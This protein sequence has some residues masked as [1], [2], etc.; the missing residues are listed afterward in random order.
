MRLKDKVALV[1][2]AANGIG[3]E[4][5]RL[6]V[7]EGAKVAIFDKSPRVKEV[8]STIS[9]TG[10]DVIGIEGDVVDAR[11]VQEAVHQTTGTFGG[12]DVLVNNAG[13]LLIRDIVDTD[14]QDWDATID[15]NLKGT[16]FFSKFAVQQMIGQGRGGSIVNIGSDLGVVGLAGYTAYCAAKGAVVNFTRALAMECGKHG[17][18]VN[19]VC[20]ASIE[21]PMMMSGLKVVADKVG[22]EKARELY[23]APLP[24]GRFGKSLD[25]ARAVLFVA[26]D[27]ASYV[28]GTILMCDGG[29]T[30]H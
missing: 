12:L 2:G 29:K 15:V 8:V 28:T 22:S 7:A 16:F 30:C 3:T 4:I 24:I 17:I 13:A 19:C 1:T 5:A 21:T 23:L 25:I 11:N 26:S 6:F 18:R 20:P 10:G 9:S 27:E 14:A